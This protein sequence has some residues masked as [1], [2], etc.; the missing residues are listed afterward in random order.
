MVLV[1]KISEV[2]NF[3]LNESCVDR[4]LLWMRLILVTNLKLAVVEPVYEWLGKHDVWTL[5]IE[6]FLHFRLSKFD[7][8]F[9]MNWAQALLVQLLFSLTQFKLNLIYWVCRFL[10]TN[11]R[12]NL[13][14]FFFMFEMRNLFIDLFDD[15]LMFYLFSH[16]LSQS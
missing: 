14:D 13:R 5:V 7:W 2:L 9:V 3:L 10:R 16:I 6:K 11:M 15:L 4:S 12:L 1:T 8:T